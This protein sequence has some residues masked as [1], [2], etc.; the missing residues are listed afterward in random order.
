MD[1]NRIKKLTEHFETLKR[2]R[3]PWEGVWADIDRFVC[4]QNALKA[5]K[6]IFDSTA[7]WCREQLASGLQMLL[8]NRSYPWFNLAVTRKDSAR[9]GNAIATSTIGTRQNSSIDDSD[10]KLWRDETEAEINTVFS[11]PVS[12]FYNQVHEFFLNLTG[13]GTGVFYIEEASEL[14]NLMFFRSLDLNECFVE[15][16]QFGRVESLHRFFSLSARNAADKWPDDAVFQKMTLENKQDE[17]VE[18]LHIVHK[19]DTKKGFPYESAYIDFGNSRLIAEGGYDYF[20]YLVTRWMVQGSDGYGSAPGGHVMPDIKLLNTLRQDHIKIMQ[21]A[22]NPPLLV[23]ENGYH[24]P[25]SITPGSINF[26]RNGI[27]DP[28]RNVSPMEN[29]EISFEEMAQCRDAI[30]K[31]FYMDIFRMGKESKEMTAAEVQMRSEEQMRLMGA[32]VGRIETEFLNPLILA[33]YHIL[34]KYGRIQGIKGQQGKLPD[35][36]IQYLSPLSRAQKSAAYNSTEAVLGFLQRSGIPN[37]Y[38]E[39]YDNLNW[40]RVLRLFVDLKGV[41]EGIM[42]T[43]EEKIQVQQKRA[44]QIQEMQPPPTRGQGIQAQGGAR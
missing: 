30:M 39:I 17:T 43:E 14:P 23:P 6:M 41:P 19:A 21:K 5:T 18:I 8:V 16:N 11:D 2:K 15:Q 7:I 26:Y 35:I 29:V 3:Q 20:P 28:I 1:A 4:P 33:V 13:R 31:A 10:L 36:D 34:G 37:I 9:T 22:L 25:L 24:L 32:I 38:P 42:N 44:M 12:N 27:A 40:D